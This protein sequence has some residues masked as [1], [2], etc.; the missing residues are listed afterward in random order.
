MWRYQTYWLQKRLGIFSRQTLWDGHLLPSVSIIWNINGDIYRTVVG[1][2]ATSLWSFAKCVY[3]LDNYG[4][5]FLWHKT[6]SKSLSKERTQIFSYL[7]HI[8]ISLVGFMEVTLGLGAWRRWTGCL[9]RLDWVPE[10]LGLY[11]PVS[12]SLPWGYFYVR[13]DR[14]MTMDYLLVLCS[15][16]L[17]MASAV[18]GKTDTFIF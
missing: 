3:G 1:S 2:R 18:E 17:H 15:L 7:A 6:H 5:S 4:I 16:W 12:P 9:T 14:F 13:A 8:P 10:H 11:S